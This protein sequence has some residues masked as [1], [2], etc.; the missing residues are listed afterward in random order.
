MIDF[1][2]LNFPDFQLK[3][4]EAGDKFKIFD[5]VRKKYFAL[6][7]EEWVRQHCL[8]M[9]IS[10]QDVPAALIAVEKAFAYNTRT[11]RADI[12]VYNKVHK[13]ILLIEC[14]APEINITEKT[15]DQIFRYNLV[16]KVPYLWVTNGREHYIAQIDFSTKK[17][18]LL[19]ALPNFGVMNQLVEQNDLI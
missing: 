16:L 5:P 7:P 4:K 17:S 14:K 15:F 11:Y 18:H 10:F 9:L 6:T 3:M 8:H 1:E 13:P 2:K 19:T 12:V